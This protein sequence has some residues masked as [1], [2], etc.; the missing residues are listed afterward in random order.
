VPAFTGR[1]GGLCKS[2]GIRAGCVTPL[3]PPVNGGIRTP[4]PFTGRAG[5]GVVPLPKVPVFKRFKKPL[6]DSLNLPINSDDNGDLVFA[7]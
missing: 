1:A 3:N 2:V 5:E 7:Q 4:S 6:K